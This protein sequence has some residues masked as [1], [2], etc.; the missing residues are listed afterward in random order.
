L[1]AVEVAQQP[2]DQVSKTMFESR[3]AALLTELRA[4]RSFREF[5]DL[6]GTTHTNVRQWEQ[7]KGEPRLRTL[8][9]IA[10]LKGW[11]LD[12]LQAYLEGESLLKNSTS[13]EQLIE[14]VRRLSFEAAAQVAAVAVETMTTKANRV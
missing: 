7:G 2:V 6:I 4:G 10:A 8:G 12:E 1:A 11:T 3:L 13:V 9:K 5:A 14:E